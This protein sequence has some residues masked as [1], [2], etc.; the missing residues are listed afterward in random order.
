MSDSIS[1]RKFAKGAGAFAVAS[2]AAGVS[3]KSYSR[4]LGAND[5]IHCAAVGVNNRGNALVKAA[6]YQPNAE[7]SALCDVDTRAIVKAMGMMKEANPE[8][9][10]SDMSVYEDYREL[11][12]SKDI[13]AVMIATPEHW[14]APMALMAL[15]AGKHCYLEKPTCHNP[16][17]GDMLVKAQS[18]YKPLIQVGT[19]Q[20]SA[21]SSIQA[22]KDI[23]DGIIG[24]V[25]YGKAWYSNARK[26]IGRK[27]EAP[28]PEWLN[29]ELWQGPAPRE[30]YKD[31]Y[32]HYDWHWFWQYGTGEVNN[33]GTHEIDICRLAMGL[34]YPNS[35]SSSGGRFHFDDDWEFYDTQNVNYQ[36]DEG[37]MITW[38][39]RSCNK[40]S[41]YDRGRGSLLH[42]TNGSIMLDRNSYIAY[43]AQ[44]KKIKE[45]KE[46]QQSATTD[47]VGI[48]FLDLEHMKN[49]MQAIRTGEKLRAPIDEGVI[50]NNMCH[51]GNYSQAVG[52]TLHLDTKT[53]KIKNDAEAMKYWS[54]EYE[55]GWEMKV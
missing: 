23:K 20:R 53:G 45:V 5:R 46:A 49:F 27:K 1:R 35:V 55:P 47:T 37:K 48:G 12:K 43:D 52:R 16:A 18:I 4:I 33:N 25:Y 15:Q 11:L 40:F 41:Q 26:S 21:Q 2:V 28:I 3:A 19:Q 31:I 34:D 39:G 44:G 30:S 42:G 54:R 29:W 13:D 32:V 51:L 38:E 10:A 9:S 6:N 17:E 7:V 24:D 14:H 8:F 22:I 36:Y 50:T